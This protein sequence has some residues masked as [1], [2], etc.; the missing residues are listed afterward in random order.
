MKQN[1]GKLVAVTI[2]FIL[3]QQLKT[4]LDK[5]GDIDEEFFDIV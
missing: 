1:F 3:S 4:F 2:S 5:I